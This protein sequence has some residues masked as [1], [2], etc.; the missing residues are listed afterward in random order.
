MTKRVFDEFNKNT[1]P[2][3][4]TY[5][6]LNSFCATRNTAIKS[7]SSAKVMENKLDVCVDDE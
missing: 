6:V 1:I 5:A 4:M 2:G 3:F 7:L